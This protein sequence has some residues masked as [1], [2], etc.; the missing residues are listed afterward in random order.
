MILLT[1]QEITS[2]IDR[3]YDANPWDC[4][5]GAVYEAIRAQARKAIKVL[6]NYEPLPNH[7]LLFSLQEID[8]IE[9]L[10]EVG[11]MDESPNT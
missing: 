1:K 2:I 10:K 8:M 3:N 4:A 6:L 5:D 11:L 7:M 9:I